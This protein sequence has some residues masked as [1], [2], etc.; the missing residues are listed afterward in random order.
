MDLD[1][2]G[3]TRRGAVIEEDAPKIAWSSGPRAPMMRVPPDIL[4][5]TGPDDHPRHLI[6]HR[7]AG[8]PHVTQGEN[9][10]CH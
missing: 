7:E 6:G 8:E 5:I 4:C 10:I 1:L 2:D 9:F 3:P